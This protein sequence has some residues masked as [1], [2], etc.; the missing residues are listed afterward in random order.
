MPVQLNGRTAKMDRILQLAER[1]DLVVV[2]DAA[3]GVGSR[4]R[5]RSAG[6]FGM[7]GTY[8]FYPA[9][10]LGCFGDGGAVVTNS[11]EVATTLRLLRDHGRNDEGRVVAWGVNSRLDNIQAAVLLTRLRHLDEE[12]ARR[13]EVAQMYEDGLHDIAGLVLPPAPEADADHFDV[14]QNY[15]IESD[16]R[17]DLRAFLTQQGVATLIQWAGTPVHQFEELKLDTQLPLTDALF[18]RCMLL[19]MNSMLTND[20]VEIVISEIRNFYGQ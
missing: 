1:H 5:G 8:S 3:Q 12:I 10:T 17:D 4:Y 2:E 13:R 14:Y 6:S 15:E 19:P 20:E 18:R 16:R 11:G 9:K 7:A